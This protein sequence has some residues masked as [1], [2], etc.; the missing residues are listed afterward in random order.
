MES[1]HRSSVPSK[2]GMHPQV[3]PGHRGIFPLQQ[4]LSPIALQYPGTRLQIPPEEEDDE[5]LDELDEP[6]EAK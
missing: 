6:E 5:L 3:P 1:Q 4:S 2:A